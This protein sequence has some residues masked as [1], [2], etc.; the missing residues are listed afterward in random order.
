M[1]EERLQIL[2]MLKEDKITMEEANSLLEALGASGAVDRLSADE[3]GRFLRVRV[4]EKGKQRVNV[5]LPLELI[6]V[7][8]RW[9][10]SD[11]WKDRDNAVD[12]EEVIRLVQEGVRG[13]LIEVTEE[14]G[15]L[16]EVIVQ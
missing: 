14:D 11:F 9:I 15:T 10:P 16:V 1:K 13:K 5:S 6:R 7:A 4:V 8:A 2:Q 3:R 12:W